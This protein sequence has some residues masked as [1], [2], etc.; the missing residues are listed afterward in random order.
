DRAGWPYKYREVGVDEGGWL[1][2]A[3]LCKMFRLFIMALAPINE[4][5]NNGA[6]KGVQASRGGT[7]WLEGHNKQENIENEIFKLLKQNQ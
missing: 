4:E 6:T 3:W 5:D 1:A 2:L 7:Q